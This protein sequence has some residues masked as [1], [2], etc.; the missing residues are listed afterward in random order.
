V[1]VCCAVVDNGARGIL[2]IKSIP[3]T[4]C[5]RIPDCQ[6]ITVIGKE[7]T[8]QRIRR[9]QGKVLKWWIIDIVCIDCVS[10]TIHITVSDAHIREFKTRFSIHKDC[11]NRTTWDLDWISLAINC[12]IINLDV[13]TGCGVCQVIIQIIHARD[14][15]YAWACCEVHCIVKGI[16]ACQGQV[17]NASHWQIVRRITETVWVWIKTALTIAKSIWIAPV[18]TTDVSPTNY[19]CLGCV[20]CI[21]DNGVCNSVPHIHSIVQIIIIEYRVDH[22]RSDDLYT[23]ISRIAYVVWVESV[24]CSWIAAQVYSSSITYQVSSRQCIVITWI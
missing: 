1:I 15:N 23:V 17:V 21:V 13:D 20:C 5:C 12:N 8:W 19:V 3:D 2:E 24:V 4:S 10:S 6:I 18:I 14:L 16:L 9:A 11:P 22:G 7:W